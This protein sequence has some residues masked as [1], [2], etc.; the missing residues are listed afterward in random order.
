MS[1]AVD[2][3]L[4]VAEDPTGQGLLGEIGLGPKEAVVPQFGDDRVDPLRRDR[5]V[6]QS[7][8][9]RPGIDRRDGDHAVEELAVGD[10]GSR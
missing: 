3:Q 2:N 1:D 4:E 6:R 7:D 8:V 10:R 5:L 9:Q